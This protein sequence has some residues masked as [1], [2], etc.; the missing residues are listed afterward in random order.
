MHQQTIRHFRKL[1]VAAFTL[2]LL[3]SSSCQRSSDKDVSA[4]I[5]ALER[6]ALDRW[7]KG[8]P[9]GYLDRMAPEI[10]Y[11]DPAVEKRIDDLPAMRAYLIPITGKIGISHYDMLAPKVQR[12]GAVA[13]LTFNLIDYGAHLEGRTDV[14]T[15][16][17]STE[18]YAQIDGTW[19]IIHS[20]WSYIKPD[21]K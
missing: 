13:V 2:S 20:H 11:F 10:T 18:I 14:A 17:N 21:L 8:D 16:W 19:R 5:V 15:R 12:H 7:G 1:P 3:L 4:E 6:A 9:Q